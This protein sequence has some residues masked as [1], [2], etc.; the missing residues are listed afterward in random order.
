VM[1]F[2]AATP[3]EV[4]V[5]GAD[6]AADRAFAERV[7]SSLRRLAMLRDV[8]LGQ[9]LDYPAVDVTIDRE[10]AGVLGVTA[11]DVTQSVSAATASSRFTEPVYW[12]AG[13]GV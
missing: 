3:I 5:S 13:N 12:A 11:R 8:Q 9:P 7:R 10:R 6:L 4:A 2:G 1:S